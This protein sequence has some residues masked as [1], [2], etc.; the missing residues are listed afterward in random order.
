MY[1]HLVCIV[2]LVAWLVPG[3]DLSRGSLPRPP[4]LGALPAM[5]R[6]PVRALALLPTVPRTGTAGRAVA[7]ALEVLLLA[8]RLRGQ[9]GGR[10]AARAAA[11]LAKHRECLRTYGVAVSTKARDVERGGPRGLPAYL[12]GGALGAGGA[13]LEE[14][15]AA[16]ALF[17]PAAYMSG[18]QPG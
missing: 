13:A 18:V 4:R 3:S 11:P 17:A 10:H 7:A 5:P 2:L 8:R 14:Q 12:L 6:H 9:A 1:S 16:Q 15:L